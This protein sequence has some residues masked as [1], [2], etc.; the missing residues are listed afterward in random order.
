MT[1]ATGMSQT[2]TYPYE[3]TIDV[4]DMELKEYSMFSLLAIQKKS[5]HATGVLDKQNATWYS[6]WC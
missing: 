5:L 4:V 3:L 1:V 2:K 6:S